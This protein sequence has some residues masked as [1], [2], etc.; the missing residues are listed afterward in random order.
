MDNTH[1]WCAGGISPQIDRLKG[2]L[3]AD[4]PWWMQQLQVPK[5]IYIPNIARMPEEACPEKEILQAQS[6]Q[7]RLAIPMMQ[8]GRLMG[9]I[10]FDSVRMQR[11]WTE[12]DIKL[13]RITGELLTTVLSRK[14]RE[15]ERAMLMKELGAK[16]SE[17]ERFTYTVSHD[18]RSPLIT[19]QGFLGFLKRDI[20]QNDK[21][22][23]DADVK[24]MEEAVKKMDALLADTLELSRIGR[25]ANPPQKA[26]YEE[27]VQ[28]A[29]AQIAEKIR[30]CKVEVLVEDDLPKVNVDRLRITEALVNLIDNS[31][32]YMGGQKQPRIEIGWTA[33]G[34]ACPPDTADQHQAV[35]F[36]SDNGMG[37]D[38][39]HHEKVFELFYKLDRKSQGSGAGLAIV[40]RIIEV[41][42]GRIW[43][44]S[45]LGKG[46]RM[47]FT[48][49]LAREI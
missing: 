49:P 20:L 32:K 39:C 41:H 38:P 11:E 44:E 6:I 48:L 27:I 45:F 4:Y 35:F 37:I 17:M 12:E 16:N 1:E 28:D 18:L 3:T 10:G 42:G 29:L 46:C 14:C 30:S 13:L 26:P 24:M 22:K 8:E 9:Y 36:V 2:L 40:K 25:A 43:I 23:C 15:S 31:I 34:I 19:I 33:D 47:C 21:K 7:S 5:D